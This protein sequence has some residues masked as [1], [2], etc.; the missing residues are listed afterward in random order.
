MAC[1][2][3]S[4]ARFT[5]SYLVYAPFR[6]GNPSRPGYGRDWQHSL[7]DVLSLVSSSLLRLDGAATGSERA[8]ISREEHRLLGHD[9]K[10][11]PRQGPRRDVTVYVSFVS[12]FACGCMPYM[13][14]RHLLDRNGHEL[15]FLNPVKSRRT[16]H[17]CA[18]LQFTA[19]CY[20]VLRLKPL[21]L[22]ILY[23]SNT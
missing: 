20:A 18:L 22:M 12:C 17:L 14:V 21:F 4:W 10:Q 3:T 8:V 9:E 13:W 6:I 2:I 16:T 15:S 19:V 23:Y 5:G 7:I 11:P 1:H